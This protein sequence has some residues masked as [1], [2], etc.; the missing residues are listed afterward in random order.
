VGPRTQQGKALPILLR[1]HIK[2]EKL[3]IV[4]SNLIYHTVPDDEAEKFL[5]AALEN[6]PHKNVQGQ[7]CLALGI[8]LKSRADASTDVANEAEKLLKLAVEKYGDLSRGE[9]GERA[10]GE[11]FELRFL[12][13]GKEAPEI[14]GKD[15]EGIKFKLSDY[16]GKVV[17]LS[18]WGDW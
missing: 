11:L 18:F 16:R 3:D 12:A 8:L 9:V 7:A 13:I 4:C 15:A 5:R 10:M 6:N 17:L 1:D 14:E 2:S